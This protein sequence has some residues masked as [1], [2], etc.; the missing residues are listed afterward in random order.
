MENGSVLP[1]IGAMIFINRVLIFTVSWK[2]RNFPTDFAI[3]LLLSTQ[4]LMEVR[5]LLRIT[6]SPASCATA[7]PSPIAK[8]MSA[9]FNAGAS[10]TPSPVIPQT[11]SICC[12]RDTSLFL[13]SGFA[14]LTTLRFGRTFFS[15]SSDNFSISSWVR[16]TSFFSSARIP[17]S[18]AMATAVSSASPVTI[19]TWIPASLRI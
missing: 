8:P 15:S 18:F 12:E 13:S 11:L 9:C 19:T 17:A 3:V 1:R 10:F 16:T 14:R 2:M 4:S 7:V 6:T 5:L